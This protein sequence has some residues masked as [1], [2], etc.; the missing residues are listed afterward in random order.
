VLALSPREGISLREIVGGV[1]MQVFVC[2]HR[3]MIAAAIPHVTLM[4]YR[5]GRIG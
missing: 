3:A 2:D 5:R 4:E 1:A